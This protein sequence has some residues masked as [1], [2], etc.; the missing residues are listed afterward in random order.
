M[1]LTFLWPYLKKNKSTFSFIKG[2]PLEIKVA[3]AL[4]QSGK[5]AVLDP[6]GQVGPYKSN[7]PGLE[8]GQHIPVTE[9]MGFQGSVREAREFQP[10]R[11]LQGL[12]FKGHSIQ[13][14]LQVSENMEGYD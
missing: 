7:S 12:Y 8:V 1:L 9:T 6:F 14:Y 11:I 5:A 4:Q 3:G 13:T 10:P 2:F